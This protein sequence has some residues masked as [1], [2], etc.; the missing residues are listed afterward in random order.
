MTGKIEVISPIFDAE[1]IGL[2]IQLAEAADN[3]SDKDV[4]EPL[5]KMM[6]IMV[7]PPVQYDP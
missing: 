1:Q 7:N 4:R 3:I 5:L 6:K 2:L